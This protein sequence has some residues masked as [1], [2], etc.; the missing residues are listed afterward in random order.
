MCSSD[1]FMKYFLDGL[2]GP[3]DYTGVIDGEVTLSEAY[4]YAFAQTARYVFLCYAPKQQT[5]EVFR[6]SLGG[7]FVLSRTEP[8]KKRDNETDMQFLLRQSMRLATWGKHQTATTVLSHIIA[9]EPNNNIAYACRGGVF[10]SQADYRRA[11]AD[12]ERLGRTLDLY[13][14]Y[15]DKDKADVQRQLDQM[16]RRQSVAAQQK[17]AEENLRI[18]LRSQANPQASVAKFVSSDGKSS[19]R[20]QLVPGQKV[21]ISV[22][23]GEWCYVDRIDDNP[24]HSGVGWIHSGNLTWTP[25]AI[26][27]YRPATVI[28]T[29]RAPSGDRIGG[30]TFRQ[31]SGPAGGGAGRSGMQRMPGMGGI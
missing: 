27:N 2:D 1:L 29:P 20:D 7:H 13:V 10:L 9:N 30:L 22:F 12:M 23:D 18:V 24:V 15:S 8:A 19:Q 4:S 14:Q 17:F 5:P 21:S 31:Q 28:H 11:M 16:V 3:A 26:E 25:D 6:E